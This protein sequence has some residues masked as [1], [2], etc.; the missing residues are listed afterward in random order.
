MKILWITSVY[1]SG[2]Y[3]GNGVFHETQVR[4]LTSLGLDITV[5]NPVPENLLLVRSLKKQYKSKRMPLIEERF[6]VKIYRPIYRAL[7]GQL[8]WAQPDK[9]IAKSVLKTINEYN[10]EADVIHAHFAMPSGGAANIVANTLKKPWIVTLHGSDVHIYPNF[11]KSAK[12]IF[13][14]TV[15]AANEVVAV[16][17]NLALAAQ[18]KTGRECE[19]LPIGIDLTKFKH[20]APSKLV[21]RKMLNLPL[22]KRIITFIGR[23]VKEKGVFELAESLKYLPEDTVLVLVGDGTARIRL[24][25][26]EEFNKRLF[27]TGQINNDRVKDYLLASDVFALPSYSEGM[28]TVVIEAVSLKIP[29][30]CTNVGGVPDLFG[31]FQHM[32]IQP[33]SVESLVER[34]MDYRSE[35]YDMSAMIEELYKYIHKHYHAGRNADLLKQCY[36]RVLSSSITPC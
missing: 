35:R 15:H 33:R 16:G 10:L 24:E 22:E 23:L 6:G 32:L 25:E 20:E 14:K 2:K 17:K 3:P 27:L 8:R 21:L 19:V 26:H 1:P 5:I 11:S 18:E 9:R 34:L 12:T 31:D 7:P 13:L 36:E 29:V 4:A 28:P 30:I